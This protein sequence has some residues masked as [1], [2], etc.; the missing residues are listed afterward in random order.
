MTDYRIYHS[1]PARSQGMSPRRMAWTG[2]IAV[3]TCENT[4]DTVAPDGGAEGVANYIWRR[5][6]A[7]S[8]HAIVDSD[9]IAW[10]FP[11]DRW[12][13]W[14]I[15]ARD[16]YNRRHNSYTA[17]ISMAYKARL[18]GSNPQYEGRMID[19]CG[20]GIAEM[21]RIWAQGDTA[22]A[23]RAVRWI[24]ADQVAN[25]EA[26]LFTHGDV[27]AYD[28]ED[29]WTRH[30]Q[31]RELQDQL[32]ASIRHYLGD[33]G[34]TAKREVGSMLSTTQNR[35]GSLEDFALFGGKPFHRWQAAPGQG[36]WS[37][38]VPLHGTPDDR[39]GPRNDPGNFDNIAAGTNVDGRIEVTAFHSY[40]G[41][42]GVFR[43]WQW[44]DGDKVRWSD[45]VKT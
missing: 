13:T 6:D 37:L 8:Y 17:S 3:H 28:R 16:R 18:W 45:W 41:V 19:R 29:A 39:M 42:F 22:L 12:E 7:G 23:L 32:S 25:G 20:E 44:Y 36:P 34:G 1:N 4:P 31:R 11:P 5:S 27:Q 21:L 35:Y 30:P 2:A 26:G 14:S 10:L 15:A 43:T 9:S 24:S 40:Y 38:W 33:P